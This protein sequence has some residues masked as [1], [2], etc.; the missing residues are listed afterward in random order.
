MNKVSIII[1]NWNGKEHLKNCLLSIRKNT[2]YPDYEIIVVDQGSVDGSV[3]MIKGDF[4]EVRLIENPE[5]FGIPKASNQAFNIAE[6]EYFFLLGNDTEVFEGWMENA[7][8][9]MEAY[10]DICTVGSTQVGFDDM[11]T[12]VSKDSMKKRANVNSVGMLI[13]RSVVDEI[14]G[15]DE[16]NFTPYGGDETD[17]NFRATN[18]GYR[19]VEAGNVVVAHLHSTDTKKQNPDQRLLLETHRLKA[20]LFN[21]SLLQ[22]AKRMP[23]LGLIF[24]QSFK[25]G[26]TGVILKSYWNNVRNWR[27]VLK[28]RKKRK[29]VINKI[30][31]KR[32]R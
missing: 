8:K 5:N 13:R 6:G 21:L 18:A 30:K 9:I 20:Y 7:V 19:I 23:G 24:V 25:E 31:E 17:W 29:D 28:E 27:T 1:L 26:T 15:Y 12:Y 3:E 4:Q 10:P 14:G 11:D 2:K 32:K 22:F 16:E